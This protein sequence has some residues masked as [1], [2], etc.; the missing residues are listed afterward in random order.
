MAVH[1]INNVDSILSGTC[2]TVLLKG[3]LI[4]VKLDSILN[5]FIEGKIKTGYKRNGIQ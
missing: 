4:V 1:Q 3:T 5:I 2:T